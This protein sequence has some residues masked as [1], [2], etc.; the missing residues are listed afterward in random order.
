MVFQCKEIFFDIPAEGLL[1]SAEKDGEKVLSCCYKNGCVDFWI[2]YDFDERPLHLIGKAKDGSKGKILLLP[3]RIELW[4]DGVLMDEEWPCGSHFLENSSIDV[5]GC[6]IQISDREYVEQEEPAV[7]GTFQNAEGWRPEENVFVGDC[8]P[9][10]HEGVYHV[11]YLKDRHHHQS[12]WRKGAHQWSHISTKN[13]VDWEIHPMAVAIDDPKEGSICTGSWI[14][15]EGKHYLY[16]T[17]R[18]CDGS[19]ATICRSLSEDGYHF[20]KDRE[21]SFVLSERY[22]AASARDP[23]I[24]KDEQGLFHMI[25]TTSLTETGIGCLAHLVSDDLNSWTELEEPLY[26]APEDKGEPEC[27]DYFYKD[28]YYYLICSLR[29]R[30]YYL[31]SKEPFSGWK[32]AEDPIPCESVPKAAEWNGRLIFTGFNKMNDYAGT[33]TFME[34]QVKPDGELTYNKL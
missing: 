23:K 33:L 25:I 17:V 12:K 8:M 31:Y 11:L 2:R 34:A 3:F 1:F 21:F 30:A 16:Y 5:E 15:H 26:I 18:M 14:C 28:G 24:V 7:V 20:K 6:S 27:P 13:F 19:P 29:G 10:A 22:T 32:Q 9:Y 4:I